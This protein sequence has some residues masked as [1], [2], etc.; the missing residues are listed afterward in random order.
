M[1]SLQE[2]AV[3]DIEP[4]DLSCLYSPSCCQLTSDYTWW[5]VGGQAE[6]WMGRDTTG[7]SPTRQQVLLHSAL[8]PT[9]GGGGGGGLV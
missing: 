6:H 8:G 1:G 3:I 2:T 9:W 7:S 5:L 4:W